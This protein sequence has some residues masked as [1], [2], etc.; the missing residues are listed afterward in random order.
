MLAET[1]TA[2]RFKPNVNLDAELSDDEIKDSKKTP[3][4]NL[5]KK[6]VVV[7]K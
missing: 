2:K 7:F 4:T 6:K 1:K 3:D 5:N